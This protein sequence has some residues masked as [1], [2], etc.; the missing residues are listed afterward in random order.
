MVRYREGEKIWIDDPKMM[1]EALSEQER[2]TQ[3]DEWLGMIQEYLNTPLPGNWA[4]MNAEQRRD[5][6]QGTDL[7]TPEQRASFTHLRE[8]VSL[9][10]IRYELLGEDLTRGAGG[11]NESSR[12]LGRVMNVMPGWVLAKAPR[13][14]AFGKQK[15]YIRKP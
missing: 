2:F 8:T 9:A 12:H 13:K 7:T 10:E 11:N 1:Q 14:T 4:A 15:V 5:F 6:I 3:Q